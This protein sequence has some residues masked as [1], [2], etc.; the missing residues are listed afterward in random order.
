MATGTESSIVVCVSDSCVLPRLVFVI[1]VAA[2]A[3]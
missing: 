3:T 2:D 1:V